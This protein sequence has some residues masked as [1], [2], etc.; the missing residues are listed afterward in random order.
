MTFPKFYAEP[1][2]VFI[3]KL[4]CCGRDDGTYGPVSWSE[5]DAFRESY[6][7]AEGHDRSAIIEAAS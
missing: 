2:H 6:L 7:N 3:V 4:T 5:A 1:E